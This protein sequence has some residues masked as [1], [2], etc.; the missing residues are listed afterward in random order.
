MIYAVAWMRQRLR[1]GWTGCGG[2]WGTVRA[3]GGMVLLSS[4]RP[5]TGNFPGK[6]GS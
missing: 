2:L 5:C 6:F 1:C 3:A 4:N